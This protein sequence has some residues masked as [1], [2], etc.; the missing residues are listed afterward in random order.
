MRFIG[1]TMVLGCSW[2]RLD[3]HIVCAEVSENKER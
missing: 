2:F 1:L 3:M